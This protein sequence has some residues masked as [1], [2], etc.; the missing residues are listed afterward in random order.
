VALTHDR[1]PGEQATRERARGGILREAGAEIV[2]RVE[3]IGDTRD[4]DP[5]LA[6]VEESKLAVR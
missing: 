1:R 5:S 4:R 3:A 2:E 6:I